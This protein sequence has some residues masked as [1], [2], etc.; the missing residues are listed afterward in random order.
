MFRNPSARCHA[1]TLIELLV[2]IAIIAIL[3][4]ILFPVFAQAREK[5]RA[6]SCLSNTKQL[7]LAVVMYVQ[8]YD[9]VYPMRQNPRQVDAN[10][11][12]PHIYEMLNA[13]IRNGNGTSQGGVWSCPSA[14]NPAQDNHLG[15]NASVFPD[16]DTD[17]DGDGN[18]TVT[19]NYVRMA[20]V[21]RPADILA[22][23]DKGANS[24]NGNW[25]EIVTDQ[26]SFA[27]ASVCTYDGPANNGCGTINV[28][29]DVGR[30]ADGSANEAVCKGALVRN[31]GDCDL[32]TGGQNW[33]WD[34]SCFLR[35]R[36]RHN[37]TC[38]VTFLD[39]HSKAMQRGSLSFSRNLWIQSV[40]GNLW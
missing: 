11:N 34:R 8:D 9:E 28:N 29:A 4:A 23:A 6:I 12:Y 24:G 19:T 2:V 25:M 7:G 3:A 38:N 14:L 33:T 35:P 16:G 30:C 1:F 15:W 18:W 39:G 32:A 31:W 26:W 13:Y 21:E 17:W 20:A 40:H 10:G 5:A 22:L 36:Y 37:G 27:D